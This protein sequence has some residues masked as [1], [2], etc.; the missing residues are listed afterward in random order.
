MAKCD[1]K[2]AGGG[3]NN[4]RRKYIY[5]EKKIDVRSGFICNVIRDDR[6]CEK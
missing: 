4:R 2:K 1:L 6:L 5:D 3:Y